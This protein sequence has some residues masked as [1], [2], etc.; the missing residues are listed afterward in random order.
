[1][2][3]VVKLFKKL[4]SPVDAWESVPSE[5]SKDL[6]NTESLVKVD[7]LVLA[8]LEKNKENEKELSKLNVKNTPVWLQVKKDFEARA[9]R[10]LVEA[11]LTKT[12]HNDNGGD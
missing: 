6:A 9:F 7:D 12:G 8:V 5:D 4:I 3:W 11:C 10:E 1:M 2:T